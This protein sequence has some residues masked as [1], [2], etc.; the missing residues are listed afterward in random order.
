[1]RFQPKHNSQPL[2][3]SVIGGTKKTGRPRRP[4]GWLLLHIVFDSLDNGFG[5]D[6]ETIGDEIDRVIGSAIGFVARLT[7]ASGEAD[8]IA[9]GCFFE[10]LTQFAKQGD[11]APLRIGLPCLAFAAVVIGGNR[12]VGDVLGGVDPA[13]FLLFGLVR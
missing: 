6:R 11:A 8:K 1:V 5:E 7:D 3:F 4:A 2:N 10:P 9:N 13:P 12:D